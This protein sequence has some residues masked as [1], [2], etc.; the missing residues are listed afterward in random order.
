MRILSRLSDIFSANF[1]ALLD[2]VENPEALLA[3]VVREMEESVAATRG[4]AASAIAAERRIG[5]ELEQNRAEVEHWQSKAREALT[6]GREDLA[7][8]ALARKR[9]HEDLV[10]G[11]QAHLASASETARNVR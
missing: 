9:E 3:H 2:Q 11:L 1:H 8:R 5:R 4:Y 7:R 10:T 6:A